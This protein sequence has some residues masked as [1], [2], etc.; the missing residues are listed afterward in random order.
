MNE[1]DIAKDKIY[2]IESLGQDKMRVMSRLLQIIALVS[3]WKFLFVKTLVV[4][5][6]FMV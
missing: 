3:V 6:R 4:R 5:Q 1:A 2:V